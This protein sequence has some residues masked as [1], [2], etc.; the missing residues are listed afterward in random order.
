MGYSNRKSVSI[1]PFRV[2]TARMG[3]RDLVGWEFLWT[4]QIRCT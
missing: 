4:V 1:G 3:V 2:S